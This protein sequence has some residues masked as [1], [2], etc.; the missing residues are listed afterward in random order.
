MSH[1]LT[2]SSDVVPTKECIWCMAPKNKNKIYKILEIKR[3]FKPNSPNSPS[4]LS[5]YENGR[6]SKEKEYD[7]IWP[8][9]RSGIQRGR[10]AEIKGSKGLQHDSLTWK[11]DLVKLNPKCHTNYS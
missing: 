2:L 4:K 8:C 5:L 9:D 1:C 7:G 6:Q 3:E 11:Y 10:L